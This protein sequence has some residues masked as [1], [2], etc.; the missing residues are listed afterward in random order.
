MLFCLWRTFNHQNQKEHEG[1][2]GTSSRT[3]HAQKARFD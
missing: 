1:L 3:R 2:P